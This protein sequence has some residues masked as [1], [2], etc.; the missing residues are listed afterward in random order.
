M[1]QKLNWLKDTQFKHFHP[2]HAVDAAWIKD[3]KSLGTAI[4]QDED[5]LLFTWFQYQEA[6]IEADITWDNPT[7]IV[8][9]R[10]YR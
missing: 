8:I 1:E 4:E 10:S 6:F 7:E 2:L 5:H 3:T 9:N